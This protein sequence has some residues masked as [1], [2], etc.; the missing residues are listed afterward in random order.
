MANDTQDTKKKEVEA[1]QRDERTRERRVYTPSADII[2]GKNGTTVIAD[3][4]GVDESS[5]DITLEKN[6]LEIYGKVNPDI[7]QD[8]KLVMSE[9]GIGDYHRRFALSDEIDRDRIQ[10]TVKKGVLRLILPRA[11][12]AKTRKIEVKAGD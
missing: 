5:V 2:E 7:P 9:Y 8:L 4:P 1:A 10:A 11:E 3:I 12:K 6:I